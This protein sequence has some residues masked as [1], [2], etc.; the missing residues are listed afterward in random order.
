MAE[1]IKMYENFRGSKRY[2][3][4]CDTCNSEVVY[5]RKTKKAICAECA[6]KKNR[7]YMQH[8]VKKHDAEVWNSAIDFF[9]CDARS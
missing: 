2:T 5:S 7:E 6:R 4:K 8:R 1:L 3:Y 9:C